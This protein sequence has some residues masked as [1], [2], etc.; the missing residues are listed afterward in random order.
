MSIVSYT[1]SM[2]II[3]T[4]TAPDWD[5]I[6]SVWLIKKY[7]AGWQDAKVEFV[8]AGER[9]PRLRKLKEVP[10]EPIVTVG[11]D[12]LIHVDTGL[13][14][15]DHHQTA[16]KTVCA[17]SLT[18]DYIKNQFQQTGITMTA[19]HIQAVDRIVK[20]IVQIDHFREV[21]WDNPTADYHEFS[22]I[23]V[24]EG[25]KIAHPEDDDLYISFGIQCLDAL[26]HE[27]ENRIWAE[28]EIAEKGIRFTLKCGE[29]MAF[30][31]IN[32]SVLKL[33]QKMGYLLVVRKDP[34][35]GY[36]RIKVRPASS[37]KDDIDLTLAYEKLSKIDPNATWYLHVSKKMLL[38]GTP[39]NPNMIPTKLTLSQ[40]V[41]VLRSLY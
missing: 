8:P 19:E 24:L 38:N 18:W 6:G 28:K 13:L 41:D 7:L 21:F 30:E 39:K 32:D 12:E 27:F 31:T 17:A 26:I 11:E 1:S 34:R 29:G 36:V 16:E 23:G 9:S 40:I 14:P 5:A 10:Y 4:H 3:V 22:L 35:K 25:L 33:A 20:V 2:K 37:E 15:L